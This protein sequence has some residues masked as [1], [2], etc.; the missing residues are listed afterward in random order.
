MSNEIEQLEEFAQLESSEL[1][2]FWQSLVDLTRHK[3]LMSED[4]YKSLKAE[5][6]GTLKYI[7]K[8]FDVIV[9]PAKVVHK[10]YKRLKSKNKNED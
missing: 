5:I 10:E 8:N 7:K 1:G 6:K 2:E 4:F 3:D 9:E